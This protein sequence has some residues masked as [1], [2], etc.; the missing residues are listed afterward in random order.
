MKIKLI[1][2]D[3]GYA[4]FFELKKLTLAHELFA[5]GM[6]P[7]IT[8]EVLCTREV[9]AAI[10]YD[11]QRDRVVMIE[12]FR[13]GPLAAGR[14]PWILDIVAGR[15]EQGHSPE[16]TARQEVKEETGLQPT[17][18]ELIGHFY[19]APHLSNER[20][21]LYCADVDSSAAGGVHGIAAEGEDIRVVTLA[22]EEACRWA[23]SGEASLWAALSIN[24]L[25]SRGAN[26]K[27]LLQRSANAH[28]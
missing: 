9:A 28:K 17:A 20:L 6:S 12:Q 15:V 11:R 10:V 8:R 2:D 7:A 3:V 22:R 19:T 1:R 13:I 5:G 25:S 14:A 26:R 21:H 24:W 4:G 23:A 16:D 27:D 18:L